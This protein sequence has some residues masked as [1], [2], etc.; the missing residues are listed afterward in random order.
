MTGGL[1]WDFVIWMSLAMV[2]IAILIS[3][4]MVDYRLTANELTQLQ[5]AHA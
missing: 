5:A 2:L 4:A 1:T 3:V